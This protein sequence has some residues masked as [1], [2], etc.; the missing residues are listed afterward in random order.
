VPAFAFEL[1]H[2]LGGMEGTEGEA[3]LGVLRMYLRKVAPAGADHGFLVYIPE[4]S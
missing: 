3:P 2:E 1:I 4:C